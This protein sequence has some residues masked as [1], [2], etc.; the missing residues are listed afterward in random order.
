[1]NKLIEEKE[2]KIW[3]EILKWDRSKITGIELRK[4]VKTSLNEVVEEERKRILEGIE[5]L[6]KNINQEFQD[7]N[8][9]EYTN[10]REDAFGDIK[11]IINK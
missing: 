6:E 9:T 7:M 1:M 4:I 3:E 8:G 5:K 2:N 10:G 11:K